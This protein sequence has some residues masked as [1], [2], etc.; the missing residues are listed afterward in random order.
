[1]DG[2]FAQAL[3]ERVD[4]CGVQRAAAPLQDAHLIEGVGLETLD[5]LRVERADLSRCPERAVVHVAPGASGDLSEFRG[6]EVAMRVAV[7][8]AHPCEGDVIEIEIE[9]HAD[10]VG[11][12]QEVHVAVLVE[13][14]LRVARAR[15]QRAEH[16]GR[17][18]PLTAHEFGDGVHIVRGEGDDGRTPGQPRDLLFARIGEVRHARARYEVGTG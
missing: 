2:R 3:F 17:P 12:D 5:Q 11:R 6:G 14:D 10:R 9:A 7:E 8:L 18:A 4:G 16:H 13:S 15:R 1:M